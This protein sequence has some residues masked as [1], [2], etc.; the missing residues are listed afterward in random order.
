MERGDEAP[1]GAPRTEVQPFDTRASSTWFRI[2]RK[3][4]AIERNVEAVRQGCGVILPRF[5]GVEAD[6]RFIE[7]ALKYLAQQPTDPQEYDILTRSGF[8]AALGGIDLANIVEE[9]PDAVVRWSF[10][11]SAVDPFLFR[12]ARYLAECRRYRSVVAKGQ[13]AFLARRY[14]TDGATASR[15]REAPFR[16]ALGSGPFVE[17]HE[18]VH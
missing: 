13:E 11:S 1:I 5:P 8:I 2:A 9:N 6:L 4:A 17:R 16:R 14:G 15:A 10:E 18:G 12:T 3:L 7:T